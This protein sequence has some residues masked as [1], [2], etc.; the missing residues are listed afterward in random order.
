MTIGS[1]SYVI[2]KLGS[3]SVVQ[4]PHQDQRFVMASNIKER[5]TQ[6]GR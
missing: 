2:S 6:T 1:I 3:E 4:M 5:S